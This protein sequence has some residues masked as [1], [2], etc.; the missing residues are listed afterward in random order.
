MKSCITPILK[1]Y[2]DQNFQQFMQRHSGPQSRILGFISAGF[3]LGSIIFLF[4]SFH[5]DLTNF[6]G[7]GSWLL[8]LLFSLIGIGSGILSLLD[9][10]R[11][12]SNKFLAVVGIILSLPAVILVSVGGL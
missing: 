6:D 3:G 2:M 10:V 7:W 8:I 1:K 5:F 12:R 11:P 9:S 4:M